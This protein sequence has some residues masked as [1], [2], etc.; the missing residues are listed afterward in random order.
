MELILSSAGEGIVGVDLHSR[1]MFMNNKARKLLGWSDDEGVGSML[2]DRT[3]HHYAD[4][5]PYPSS[6]C[7]VQQTLLDG[8]TRTITADVFWRMDGS[9][10]PVE[11]TVAAIRENNQISGSVMVFHDITDRVLM[12]QKLQELANTDPL[13]GLNNRRSFSVAADAEFQRC[14][15]FKSSAAILMIDIDWFKAVND[16]YGH[17][18]GDSA[19][20][21]LAH[22]LEN[23]IRVT[24]TA[25][26][27]GG[28][29]FVLLLVET[30]LSGALEMAER[31]RESARSIVVRSPT[32]DFSFTVSV[33]IT[34]IDQQD[35]DWTVAMSRADEAMYQAKSNGRNRVETV[36]PRGL[37]KTIGTQVDG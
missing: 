28:E 21:H 12:T 24:D 7:A 18:A 25:A 35:E 10:F 14:T 6:E 15:R 30:D 20:V 22:V 13:T 4:G 31:I 34:M 16:T 5:R 3:H 37:S 27:Y 1:I 8:L 32:G 17:D 29:E 33:G 9:S 19:L 2:H 11:F 23:S 36:V 26:R